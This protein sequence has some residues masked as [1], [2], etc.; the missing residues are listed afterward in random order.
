MR[1]GN[2]ETNTAMRAINALAG[3]EPHRR[4]VEYQITREKLD[5]WREGLPN[6]AKG[7]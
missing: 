4:F 2:A 3:F 7:L 5:R 1:T 6:I